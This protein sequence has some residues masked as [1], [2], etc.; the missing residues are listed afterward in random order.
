MHKRR[1]GRT[2]LMISE[3]GFGALEIGRDWGV[4]E[5]DRSKPDEETA[6]QLL[7]D[8]VKMGINFIDTAMAYVKSEERIGKAIAS[9]RVSRTDFYLATKGGERFDE[10]NGSIYD[11]SYEGMIR[12]LSESYERLQV[13]YI[14]LLQIH[15]ASV[16]VVRAGEAIRALRHFQDLGKC[17]FVGASFE[18]ALAC[19]LALESGDYDTIQITYNLLEQWAAQELLSLAQQVDAGVIIKLPL[20]KGLLSRKADVLAS[21]EQAHVE[22]YRFL[23]RRGQTL[24]QGALRFVLSHPAVSTVIVGTKRLEHLQEN[25]AVADGRGLTLEELARVRQIEAQ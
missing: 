14:D 4:V 24:A 17:G 5:T 8:V 7:A 18:D 9:K 19:K 23:E 2:G 3:I 21:A 13:E 22:P 10:V 15:T 12:S 6:I 11:Y 25:L 16:D 20:A 1:L